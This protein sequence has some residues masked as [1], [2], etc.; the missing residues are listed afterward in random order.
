QGANSSADSGQLMLD[1]GLVLGARRCRFLFDLSGHDA[2]LVR[3]GSRPGGREWRAAPS[4]QLHFPSSIIDGANRPAQL[5]LQK[6]ISD[7]A[8]SIGTIG[9]EDRI[10]VHVSRSL[11]PFCD[12]ILRARNAS[13]ADYAASRFGVLPSS[14]TSLSSR[15]YSFS[16]A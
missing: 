9:R 6:G 10:E 7:R 12:S 11:K 2:P 5:L 1:E 15:R 3:L 4:H 14:N 16:M 8:S 13:R